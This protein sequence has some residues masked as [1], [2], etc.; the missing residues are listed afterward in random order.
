MGTCRDEIIESRRCIQIG[1]CDVLESVIT[2]SKVTVHVPLIT[3]GISSVI[4]KYS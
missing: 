3:L 4:S 1:I 2:P